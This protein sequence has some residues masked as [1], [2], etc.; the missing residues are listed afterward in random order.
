M[1]PAEATAKQ[2]ELN[3]L[4]AAMFATKIDPIKAE[5][6]KPEDF[7]SEKHRA[8]WRAIL[9][10]IREGGEDA[11]TLVV[12]DRLRVS[13]DLESAGGASY[14]ESFGDY[15]MNRVL[16]GFDKSSAALLECS[17]LRKIGSIARQV[18]DAA[19]GWGDSSRTA[20]EALKAALET[21]EKNASVKI[22]PAFYA[23]TEELAEAFRPGLKTGTP[24]DRR[25]P[26]TPGRMY[27][28]G[29]RPGDGK[30][31]ITLQVALH[32]LRH[33]PE[34]VIMFATCEMTE[35]ELALKAL[36]CLEGRD[37]IGPLRSGQPGAMQDVIMGANTQAPILERLLI[38]P[39]RSIDDVCADS[40]RLSRSHNLQCVV[41]DYLSAFSAPAGTRAENRTLEV[42]AVSRECKALAQRL[43]CVVL[44]ASQLNRAAKA[45]IKPQAH[46]L[47]DSGCIEQDS[48]AILLLY[49]PDHD[50]DEGKAQLLIAKNR[51]GELG[52][53]EVLPDL[54]NHRFGWLSPRGE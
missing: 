42:G 13:G 43:G 33:N 53:I 54:K 50:D 28:V 34:A 37:F 31:T 48:D 38:K 46:H 40:H 21:V 4:A 15:S 30:T 41:V 23:L 24:L 36:C 11:P 17:K 45:S 9:T 12:I 51:W 52:S 1:T 47:R 16:A 32:I 2:A 18:A 22:R 7:Q 49:R 29:G 3:L 5:A 27:V 20:L 6:I 44:A 10:E 19:E 14:V 35:A 8:I 39:T 26:I 25:M